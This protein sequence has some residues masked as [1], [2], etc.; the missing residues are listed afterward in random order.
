MVLVAAGMLAG[1]PHF[2]HELTDIGRDQEV[3]NR[4]GPRGRRID[5]GPRAFARRDVVPARVYELHVTYVDDHG[6]HH[7][8]ELLLST[9]LGE[10]DADQDVE[11]RTT[12]RTWSG[13][14]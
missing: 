3:W 5:R 10:L 4:G 14:R 6:N 12:P 8:G 7:E 9:A 1:V 13:S 2:A 11:I